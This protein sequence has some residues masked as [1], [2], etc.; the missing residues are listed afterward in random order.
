MSERGGGH[1]TLSRS[2]SRRSFLEVGA[3]GAMLPRV[4]QLLDP[5]SPDDLESVGMRFVNVYR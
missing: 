4:A 1:S 5:L 3:A 2:M